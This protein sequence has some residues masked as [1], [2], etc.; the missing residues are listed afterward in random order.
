MDAAENIN[1]NN[2]TSDSASFGNRNVPQLE[3]QN[4]EGPFSGMR[5]DPHLGAETIDMANLM[6]NELIV[7]EEV[8]NCR[9]IRRLDYGEEYPEEHQ[10]QQQ[11]QHT[12]INPGPSPGSSLNDLLSEQDIYNSS[13][14]N[15]ESRSVVSFA[16]TETSL[17][18]INC[19]KYLNCVNLWPKG[20]IKPDE[21]S[22]Y[23]TLL[24]NKLVSEMPLIKEELHFASRMNFV[25]RL[26]II[27]QVLKD[28]DI[29]L[30]SPRLLE[31]HGDTCL[32]V[33]TVFNN[34]EAAMML[35]K[36]GGKRLI[37]KKYEHKQ[38][39]GT[40]ALHL[41]AVQENLVII[42]EM[43]RYLDTYQRTKLL[44]ME[45]HGRFFN[46]ELQSNGLIMSACMG[47]KH[48]FETLVEYSA[49]VDAVNSKT[50]S[51]VLQTLVSYSLYD[52]QV[53]CEMYKFILGSQV[54][55]KWWR[56]RR[57][58]LIPQC[59]CLEVAAMANHLLRKKN[60]DRETPFAKAIRN[61][62]VDMAALIM[63]TND[64]YRF[65]QWN[66][67]P[68]CFTYYDMCEVDSMLTKFQQPSA[69]EHFVYSLDDKS[70]PLLH[71]EPLK[72]LLVKKW[73]SYRITFFLWCLF[74]IA[75]MSCFTATSLIRKDE[76]GPVD[77]RARPF[78]IKLTVDIIVT[79]TCGIY[80]LGE[81]YDILYF[82]VA[83][84]RLLRRKCKLRYY[85]EPMW[86]L[87]HADKFRILLIAF[88]C[89]ALIG[90]SLFALNHKAHSIFTA[91][92]AIYGWCFTLFFTRAFKNIGIFTVML[93]R[94]IMGDL[95]YFTI[96]FLVILAGLA[97]ALQILFHANS[98]VPTDVSVMSNT[99]MNL[100]RFMV[101]LTEMDVAMYATFPAAVN[102]LI[103]G[104]ILLANVQL[105]NMLVAAMNDTY[106]AVAGNKE[107][108]WA[109]MR[110]KSVL[111][112][113]RRIPCC[114]RR[115]HT[116]LE[117]REIGR[118]TVPETIWVL[119][120]EEVVRP[121]PAGIFN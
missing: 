24:C 119:P 14:E 99:V 116:Y 74:H 92:A 67:S 37:M 115:Q 87:L 32:H 49:D 79:I 13:E 17:C 69:L 78:Y 85:R 73:Y 42:H 60:L 8:T 103:V 121:K 59:S 54:V 62:A 7:P 12:A 96:V 53:S 102:L 36:F 2:I 108:L 107:E 18:T 35:M 95:I 88:C 41:A 83:F 19:T 56:Q 111:L 50:G 31:K 20:E 93:Q 3:S 68:S 82:L 29:P 64:V 27:S 71:H 46:G 65:P 105:I 22:L 44:H 120:V 25:E 51:N 89:S 81:I 55:R 91:M 112:L 98:T 109:K 45:A 39:T 43:M 84:T 23:K 117:K 28:H 40:T 70:L 9:E 113:E 80:L 86:A 10:Q 52:T 76:W 100:F 72:S 26:Q 118:P 16:F 66:C 75:V 5:N 48:V 6:R 63:Q 1:G 94:M 114:L 21:V 58:S 61:G 97:T 11:H 34:S 47:S 15:V 90:R 33:A 77:N 110:A 30:H 38:N 101:G 106:A 57:D 104:F 4:E